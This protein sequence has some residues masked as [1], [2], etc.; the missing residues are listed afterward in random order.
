MALGV[1]GAV[2]WVVEVWWWMR[3]TRVRGGEGFVGHTRKE[4]EKEKKTM[5]AEVERRGVEMRE[6]DVVPVL[7]DGEQINGAHHQEDPTTPEP[8]RHEQRRKTDDKTPTIPTPTATVESVE[9]ADVVPHVVS[10]RV[11]RARRA[12]LRDTERRPSR[13]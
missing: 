13:M 11:T 10:S 7:S 4:K 3:A 8:V 12:A 9:V 1:A 5:D 6:R 2:A